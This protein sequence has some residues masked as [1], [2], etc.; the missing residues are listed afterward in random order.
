MGQY[1]LVCCSNFDT[2][3]HERSSEKFI[4]KSLKS[5]K[6]TTYSRNSENSGNKPKPEKCLHNTPHTDRELYP[7]RCRRRYYECKCTQKEKCCFGIERIREKSHFHGLKCRNHMLVF[8]CIDMYRRMFGSPRLN[9]NIDEIE[10]TEPFHDIEEHDR[11]RDNHRNTCYTV[12]HMDSD[13]STKTE[14]SPESYFS[15]IRE[16]V[17]RTED[18]IWTRTNQG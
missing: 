7:H 13:S 8:V 5:L 6:H 16:T 11:L 9:A 10:S 18:K 1:C 2:E 15:R 4:E 14:S 12:R 17:S 3:Y